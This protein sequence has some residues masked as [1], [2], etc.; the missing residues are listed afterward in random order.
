M[1]KI[2]MVSH[3]K[4]KVHLIGF[5]PQ[6]KIIEIKP[7]K[8]DSIYDLIVKIA[9]KLNLEKEILCENRTRVNPWVMVI[10]DE[11]DIASLKLLAENAS[12]YEQIKVISL[13]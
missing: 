5:Y 11:K 12:K 2:S 10:A 13:L 6:D 8:K 7:D 4:I 1:I 3:M 9:R